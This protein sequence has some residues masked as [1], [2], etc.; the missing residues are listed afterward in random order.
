VRSLDRLNIGASAR[1]HAVH[2]ITAANNRSQVDG[3]RMTYEQWDVIADAF[4]PILLIVTLFVPL[5]ARSSYRG[6]RGCFYFATAISLAAMYFLS[7]VD[8]RLQ[9]WRAVGWDYSTHTGLAI[10]LVVSLLFWKRSVGL[11]TVVA[12]VGY[13]VLMLYQKYHTVVDIVSTLLVVAS[14]SV[15]TH[16]AATSRAARGTVA[17]EQKAL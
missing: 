9:L 6:G 1:Q 15:A 17:Q 8:H 12:F 5:L 7:W 16:L 14:F 10:V 4:N 2:S 3:I 11:V 13:A